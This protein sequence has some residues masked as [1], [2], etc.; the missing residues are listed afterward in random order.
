MAGERVVIVSGK[1][2]IDEEQAANF[3]VVSTNLKDVPSSTFSRARAIAAT[4]RALVKEGHRLDQNPEALTKRDFEVLA[5][6]RKQLRAF[7]YFSEEEARRQDLTPQ[8]HQLLLAIQGTPGRAW[9]TVGE[10]SDF[11]QLKNHSVVGLINR[12]EL[13]GLVQRQQS[14]QDHRVTE[15]HL[16]AHGREVLDHLSLAHRRELLALSRAIQALSG[17]LEG[18]AKVVD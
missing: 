3:R 7:L 17:A 1:N 18:G 15:I 14:V 10:L 5:S 16:T 12:A 2:A 8:Q 9:A 13:M 11:L 4:P 6:F